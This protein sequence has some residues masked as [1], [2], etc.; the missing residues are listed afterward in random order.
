MLIWENMITPRTVALTANNNTPYF[1]MWIDLKEGP[2]VIEVPPKVLGV[3]DDMWCRWVVDVGFLGVDKGEGGKYLFVPPGYEEEVP[4]GYIVVKPR[5]FGMYMFWRSF[6]NEKGDPKPQVHLIKQ[7]AR[8]Y[9]F[10]RADKPPTLTFIDAT[11]KPFCQVPPADYTFWEYLNE[12]VQEE[13][14]NSLDTVTLGFFRSI[15]SKRG[16][17]F[18]PDER[19]K[20]IL[21]EAAAVG[22]ATARA[23]TYRLRE[24]DAYFY[25]NSAWRSFFAGGYEFLDNGAL[26]LDAYVQNFFHVTGISPAEEQKMIGQGSQYA[27][28]YVDADGRPFDGSKNYKLHLPPN[29]PVNNFWSA[30]IHDTQTRS[31]LQTDQ[32]WP[33]VSSQDKNFRLNE[34]GSADV[35]FG[36]QPPAG[37]ENNWIQTIPG[38][39]WFIMLR[40][41]GPL[42]PW[43]NK[44]WRP[45]EIE[46]V[47]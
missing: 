10:S 39:G 29:I 40:L 18:A 9:P 1:F 41:Y 23:I 42:E 17:P 46:L 26:I 12:V 47:K 21:R 32:H 6:L 30:I 28:A 11:D 3:I 36:P 33:A 44:T 31:Q 13:P 43:F 2:L 8:V 7:T 35:Y 25:E 16:V 38:K 15:G 4:E 45:G 19:M 27:E 37:K 20:A 14:S 22:H 24:K 34:D 5:T